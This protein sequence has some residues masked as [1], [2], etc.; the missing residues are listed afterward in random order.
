MIIWLWMLFCKG[1]QILQVLHA[2]AFS[3]T[4]VLPYD[5]AV[6]YVSNKYAS[7]P[8]DVRHADA[9]VVHDII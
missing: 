8:D 4:E 2:K 1:G 3:I 5:L 6:S 9:E 7:L